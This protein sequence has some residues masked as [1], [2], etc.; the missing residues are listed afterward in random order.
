[1][2]LESLLD[3]LT[4][5]VEHTT[6]IRE[7]LEYISRALVVIKSDVTTMI[8]TAKDNVRERTAQ[9]KKEKAAADANVLK[10][11]ECFAG[12]DPALRKFLQDSL[13]C[14]ILDQTR[15]KAAKAAQDIEDA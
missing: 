10:H 15:E 11:G 4:T 13:A 12:V 2:T 6:A 14:H 9:L 7:K 8:V 3:T 1:M 5:A